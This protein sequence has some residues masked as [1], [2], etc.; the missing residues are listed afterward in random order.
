MYSKAFVRHL[1]VAGEQLAGMIASQHNLAFYLDLK[2]EAREQILA[3]T[4]DEWK[5]KT[6]KKVAERL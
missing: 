3:G 2:R 4:F 5:E 1:Y 6:V